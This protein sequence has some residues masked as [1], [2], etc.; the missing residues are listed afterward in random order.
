MKDKRKRNAGNQALLTKAIIG[1]FQAAAR[2]AS[3]AHVSSGPMKAT[4]PS[5]YSR[6]I[7]LSDS[8]VS[9]LLSYVRYSSLHAQ[10]RTLN[11]QHVQG[12]PKMSPFSVRINFIKY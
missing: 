11:I 8:I 4:A 7:A 10:M 12:G 5:E 1:R 9:A 6:V 3:V 2:R